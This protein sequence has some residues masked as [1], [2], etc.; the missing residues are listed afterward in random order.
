MTRRK[1]HHESRI[2]TIALANSHKEKENP[3]ERRKLQQPYKRI[4]LFSVSSEEIRT[5]LFIEYSVHVLLLFCRA[6]V[7]LNGIN[8]HGEH[9]AQSAAIGL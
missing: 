6:V 5:V 2:K 8:T 7:L 4:V 3:T 1:D 9:Y